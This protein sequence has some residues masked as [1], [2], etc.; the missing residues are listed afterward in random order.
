MIIIMKLIMKKEKM[1]NKIMEF[2]EVDTPVAPDMSTI[3]FQIGVLMM[4]AVEI[5]AKIVVV[6]D[7]EIGLTDTNPEKLGVLGEEVVDLGITICI[8]LGMSV[9][10]G[11]VLIDCCREQTYIVEGIR[12]VD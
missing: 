11:L 9:G 8:D 5:G 12:I 10:I 1:K 2:R 4:L 7:E 6:L 3:G